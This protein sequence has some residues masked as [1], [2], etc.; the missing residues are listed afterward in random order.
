MQLEEEH[1]IWAGGGSRVLARRL[2]LNKTA[3]AEE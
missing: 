3:K 2:D 1:R